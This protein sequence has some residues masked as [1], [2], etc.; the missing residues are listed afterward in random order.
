MQYKHFIRAYVPRYYLN[1]LILSR[2]HH[3]ITHKKYFY[4]FIFQ[5][6]KCLIDFSHNTK[7]FKI[8]TYALIHKKP[9]QIWNAEHMQYC[10]EVTFLVILKKSVILELSMIPDHKIYHGLVLM[11]LQIIR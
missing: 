6:Q 3:E 7:F 4:L 5:Q 11:I 1:D 2:D 8:S 9:V 10:R